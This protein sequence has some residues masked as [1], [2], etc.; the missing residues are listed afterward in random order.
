MILQCWYCGCRINE[1]TFNSD[2][3]IFHRDITADQ[4]GKHKLFDH[5]P[6]CTTMCIDGYKRLKNKPSVAPTADMHIS[7][8]KKERKLKKYKSK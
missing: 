6:F 1:R 5:K 2:L 8:W 7:V 3:E 4:I